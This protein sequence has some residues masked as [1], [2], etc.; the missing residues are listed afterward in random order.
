M[1]KVLV[2]FGIALMVACTTTPAEPKNEEEVVDS[3]MVIEETVD[4]VETVDTLVVEK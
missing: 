4:T 2:L 1:K 3:T